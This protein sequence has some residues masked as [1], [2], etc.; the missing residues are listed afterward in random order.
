MLS[1][2]ECRRVYFGICGMPKKLFNDMTAFI[3]FMEI[4]VGSQEQDGVSQN[5]YKKLSSEMC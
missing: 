5:E 4:L 1:R 2:K 3:I